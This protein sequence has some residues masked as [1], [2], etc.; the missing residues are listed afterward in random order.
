MMEKIHPDETLDA[1][2]NGQ[3]FILQK[4]RGYRFSLDALLLS[5]FALPRVGTSIA[6][7][8]CGSGVI[9]VILATKKPQARVLGIEIQPEMVEMAT[10]TV[11]I[12]HLNERV[13]ILEGDVRGCA[14]FIPPSSFDSCVMNPPYRRLRSGRL[15][16]VDE[17]AI[18]RHE[19]HGSVKDFLAAAAYLL[20]PG[21]NVFIIYP[22]RR[23]AEVFYQ[24][25][26]HRLEPK[27][28]R[29]VHSRAGGR[30]EFVLLEGRLGGGEELLL[31]PPLVI[32]GKGNEY[33]ED[34]AALISFL[35]SS[36]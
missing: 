3:I 25:R 30:G 36:P 35:S 10:R 29:P 28:L 26:V 24:M 20:K 22:A 2:L 31:E 21:G 32:Y 34:M 7:L 15:N 1:L 17:K 18:A 33:T 16:P 19:I 14:S 9:A 11:K 5:A 23:M 6:D 12:N 13:R 27:R 8:G 4:K